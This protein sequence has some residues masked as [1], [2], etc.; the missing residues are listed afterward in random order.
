[1][2]KKILISFYLFISSFGFSQNMQ[3][4]IYSE[5]SVVTSGPGDNLY[6][7]F[8]HTAIR[9]KDPVLSLDLIYN[10]GIFDFD[11]PNFY[12]NFTKGFMKYKLARYDFYYALRSA[13]ED[14]RWMKQQVLN[15]TSEE[16]NNFFTFLQHNAEP[17]N[18][19]Y[20][21]DPFYDNCATRPRDIIKKVLG[22]KLTISSDFITSDTSLRQLM[23][24]EINPNTWGSFGINVALGSKLD[25]VATAEEYMYL[26]DYV[27]KA[28]EVSKIKR[29]TEEVPLVKRTQTLLDFEEKQAKSDAFSPLLAFSILLIIG[30]FTTYNDYKKLQR[31][32]WFDF[33]LFFITGVIGLLIMFLWFFTN[34]STA[35]NNFNF[36]WAFA[37]NLIVSFFLLKKN[38]PKWIKKYILFLLML[39]AIIPIIWLSKMQLFSVYLVEVFVLLVIRYIYL[40]KTLDS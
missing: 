12:L 14:K 18:A 3:L 35:P 27:F 13:N 4:S 31:T 10:Y 33:M 34:H 2:L 8:G 26:P 32:K 19:S 1:M 16:K 21:Y 39:L 29:E 15:L 38:P 36:L 7:K 37:P 22:D 24:I 20:L 40:Q 23:N 9:V 30:I 28:L 6:E 11:A 17:E 5:I 25:K